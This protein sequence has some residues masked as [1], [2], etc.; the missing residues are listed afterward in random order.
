MSAYTERA[1]ML[2]TGLRS[3][4][5]QCLAEC[6]VNNILSEEQLSIMA[7]ILD[8]AQGMHTLEDYK[9]QEYVTKVVLAQSLMPNGIIA[10]SQVLVQ[11]WLQSKLERYVKIKLEVD[12]SN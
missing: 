9:I 8:K 5:Y 10:S 1:I 3:K 12:N 11:L 4:Y 6:D 2:E 7:L